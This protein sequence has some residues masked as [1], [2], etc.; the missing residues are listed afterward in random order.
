MSCHMKDTDAQRGH[1][2]LRT[3]RD[4]AGWR[5]VAGTCRR[6]EMPWEGTWCHGHQERRMQV[7]WKWGRSAGEQ[8]VEVNAAVRCSWV[9]ETAEEFG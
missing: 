9:S 3:P 4:D 7:G 1:P 8:L 2:V 6:M 5:E